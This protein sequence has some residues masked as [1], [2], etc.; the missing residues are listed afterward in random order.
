MSGIIIQN[1]PYAECR[2]RHIV[3]HRLRITLRIGSAQMR[4]L[5]RPFPFQFHHGSRTGQVFVGIRI[6]RLYGQRSR[7]RH[8]QLVLLGP[9]GRNHH[10]AVC[11]TSSINGSSSRIFQ[12]RNAFNIFHIQVGHTFHPVSVPVIRRLF[13]RKSVNDIQRSCQSVHRSHTSNFSVT[14]SGYT[15]L[16]HGTHIVQTLR[17]QFLGIHLRECSCST[18]LGN[19]LI[20]GHHYFVKQFGRRLKNNVIILSRSQFD[21]LRLISQIRSL[22]FLCFIRKSQSEM[23]LH[24]RYNSYNRTTGIFIHLLDMCR[25]K[26]FLVFIY[27]NAMNSTFTPRISRS[28]K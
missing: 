18:F 9:F 3:E 26:W 23:S 21:S 15:S 20:T 2:I 1:I 4:I 27:Y 22:Y 5:G 25:R 24:I 16:Q 13:H 14:V 11:C 19:G 17:F 10:H 28:R 12:D 7:E 6:V 8:V